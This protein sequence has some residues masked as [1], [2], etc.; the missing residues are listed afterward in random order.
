[1]WK[2]LAEVLLFLLCAGAGA[3]GGSSASAENTADAGMLASNDITRP[4]AGPRA[5]A[6]ELD[7]GR[8]HLQMDRDGDGHVDKEEI[9]RHLHEQHKSMH[10]EHNERAQME[11]DIRA[12]DSDGDKLVTVAEYL[13]HLEDNRRA[14]GEEVSPEDAADLREAD[15]EEFAK[16]DHDGDGVITL[17]ELRNSGGFDPGFKGEI[18]ELVEHA[19]NDNNGKISVAELH[20][21]VQKGDSLSHH[22]LELLHHGLGS[23]GTASG[24]HDEV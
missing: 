22:V 20:A 10:P 9:L 4:A 19:D 3:G 6:R 21:H 18:H 23:L 15:A 1:M 11:A 5:G 12:M 8:L 14:A 2:A 13:A 17:R 24:D 16:I 7:S